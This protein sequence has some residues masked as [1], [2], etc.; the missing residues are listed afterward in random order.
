[1]MSDLLT[2]NYVLYGLEVKTSQAGYLAIKKIA[3]IIKII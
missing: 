2:K 1:M 3:G